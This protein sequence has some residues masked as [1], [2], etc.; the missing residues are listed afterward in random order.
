MN[1]QFTD[2]G[3]GEGVLA[4]DSVVRSLQSTL[5][6]AVDYMYTPSSGTTTVPTL[7]SLGISM[8]KDGTLTVDSGALTSALQNNFGD[9]QNFFQGPALNGFAN[10]I[11]SN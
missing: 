1:A 9:V 4:G 8:N 2:N 6:S 3:S 5:E 11:T 10:S 7:T